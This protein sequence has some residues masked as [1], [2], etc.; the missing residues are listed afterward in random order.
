MQ[1]CPTV[2]LAGGL[3]KRMGQP[4]KPLLELNGAPILSYVISRIKAQSDPLVLN[5]NSNQER[6]TKFSLPIVADSVAGFP[7]PLAGILAGLEYFSSFSGDCDQMLSAPADTPFLPHDLIRRLAAEKAVT[8]ASIAVAASNGRSH[9]TIA[10][11]DMSLKEDLFHALVVENMRKVS[12]FI[13][14]H[15]HIIV[16]WSASAH[17]PFF[18]IN[19][20]EDIAKAQALMQEI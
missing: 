9:H 6:F 14:R 17:D 20:P 4:D 19:F 10:L 18:N 8:G 13:M 16:D 12:T 2:I 5:V 11:W 1:S 15:P 3:S 7:G